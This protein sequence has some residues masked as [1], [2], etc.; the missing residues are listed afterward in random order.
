MFFLSCKLLKTFGNFFENCYFVITKLKP[1]IKVKIVFRDF[2]LINDT[3][4]RIAKAI[5]KL[6]IQV[7]NGQTGV[8]VIKQLF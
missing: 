3:H 1:K 2:H 5:N 8:I 4:F 6:F 7:T